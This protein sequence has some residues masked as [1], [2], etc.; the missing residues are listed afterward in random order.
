MHHE[1]SFL[2]D[3]INGLLV[4]WLGPPPDRVLFAF[5]DFQFKTTEVWLP[6]HVLN[7]ILV[8]LIL[9]VGGIWL[10][11]NLSKENPSG[12][13]QSMEIL[14]G[15]LRDLLDDVIGHHGSAHL[16]V[17]GGFAFFIL[18]ANFFGLIFFLQPPTANLNTN[19]ALALVSFVYYHIQGFRHANVAYLKQFL[20]PILGLVILFLPLEIISHSARVLSL[21]LRL[22]GNISGE[23]TANGVF[24]GI[25]PLF[26][27]WPMMLL[28]IIGACM[29][30]FIFVM[31]STVYVAGA[32]SE[33]H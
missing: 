13:Q 28:G 15:S 11:R 25:F 22:T 12:F 3:W 18:V 16:P 1:T 23:H 31:L 7:S 27:P 8:L 19:L 29:Q 2:Y 26:V 10:R 20:G 21:T 32:V 14:I 33:E 24:T 17:I 5:G 6:D 4:R 9:V 30:T